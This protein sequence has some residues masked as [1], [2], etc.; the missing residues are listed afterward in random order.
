MD[1]PKKIPGDAGVEKLWL[2]TL[3]KSEIEP[4]KEWTGDD[5]KQLTAVKPSSKIQILIQGFFWRLESSVKE[6]VKFADNED[7]VDKP[8]E[9]MFDKWFEDNRIG[10]Y[11]HAYQLL[12]FFNTI[13]R[14]LHLTEET[15][16]GTEK[17]FQ[18]ILS[19]IARRCLDEP[20]YVQK[21]R[22]IINDKYPGLA[23][24]FKSEPSVAELND[25]E[26]RRY[27]QEV[28]KVSET[29]ESNIDKYANYLAKIKKAQ[30]TDF[31]KIA[32]DLNRIVI[33]GDS[34]WELTLYSLMS[35]H[36]PRIRINKLKLRA[37]LH[38]MF[39]GD[40]ST[41]KSKILKVAKEISPK[42]M[43]VD[44]T[45]KASYEGVA[46]T[47][48]GEEI[49][50]GVLDKANGGAIIVEEFT[51]QFSKLTLFRRAMDC[52]KITIY[53]KGKAKTIDVNTTMIAACNP[54]ADFFLD[55]VEF[56]KQIPFKEGILSRFDLLIPLMATQVK[57]EM[58][59]P[60]LN[61]LT[62]NDELESIDLDEIADNLTTI[63]KGMAAITK[64]KITLEQEAKVKEAFHGRNQMDQDRRGIL[65]NRPLVILRDL[66]TLVRLVNTIAAVNFSKRRIEN[67]V[68][69]ADDS[70]IDK[71]VQLWEN[72]IQLRIQL[73]AQ[74]DRNMRSVGDEILLAVHRSQEYARSNNLPDEIP[75]DDIRQD[76]VDTRKL[77]GLTT[78]Y[79]EI[80]ILEETGRL[81]VEGKR[82][83][84]LKVIVK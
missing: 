48:P 56:R 20:E 2:E 21:V 81:A 55:E 60:K 33:F 50:E 57:N 75:I 30:K 46:P 69:Y 41:A 83:K 78:F 49:E 7:I 5:V 34:L 14:G 29:I 15:G 58:L 59:L 76:I 25:Y 11:T 9:D 12:Q 72:L 54:S 80:N 65:K 45:T 27:S 51:N 61:L 36:A 31:E 28:S 35:S 82:D 40:I 44:D 8:D 13:A 32:Q 64:V 73:Y 37:N 62:D 38:L 71:A 22:D 17:E 1:N 3:V 79:K 77:V 63:S 52:E 16:S 66:E 42:S 39:P 10:E 47:R 68:L 19:K 18:A 6:T 24:E 43:V 53:K 74:H 26:A 84:K 67:T 4:Q 70:D 23:G